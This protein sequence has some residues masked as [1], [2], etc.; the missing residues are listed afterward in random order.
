MV[1]ITKTQ[2][3]IQRLTKLF[4]QRKKILSLPPETALNAILD[5]P[6]PTALVHSFAEEDFYFLIHDIGLGDSHLLLS[7]ASD[8][9]WEYLVD[10]E[11]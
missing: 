3:R 5:S 11:V 7:L 1:K 4:E 2:K 9:Q 6:Q 8:K 10:L